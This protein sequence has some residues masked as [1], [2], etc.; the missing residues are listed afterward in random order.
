MTTSAR[1]PDRD[2]QCADRGVVVRRGKAARDAILLAHFD[3]T[4]LPIFIATRGD[5]LP[6]ILVAGG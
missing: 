2:D 5:S 4:T 1:G 3:V 6:I